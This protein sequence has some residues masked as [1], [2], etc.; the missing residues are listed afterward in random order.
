MG[1]EAFSQSLA[2]NIH[3]SGEKDPETN[4]PVV[5]EA[6]EGGSVERLATPSEQ[7]AIEHLGNRRFEAAMGPEAEFL[8]DGLMV[9]DEGDLRATTGAEQQL[10]DTFGGHKSRFDDVMGRRTEEAGAVMADEPSWRQSMELSLQDIQRGREA[11]QQHRTGSSAPL[12]RAG[13]ERGPAAYDAHRAPVSRL[14]SYNES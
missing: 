11:V 2:N 12:P 10:M 5:V 1:D 8:G 6:R 9:R 3:L 7:T 13:T 4:I 14:R